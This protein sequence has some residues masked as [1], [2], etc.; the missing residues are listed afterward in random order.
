MVNPSVMQQ[1]A[2]EYGREDLAAAQAH[3]LALRL[4]YHPVRQRV[5]WSLVSLG[6]RLTKDPI[7]DVMGQGRHVRGTPRAGTA[8]PGTPRARTSLQLARL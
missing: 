6:M 5:G 1:L 7:L 2:R 4:S 8:P 3:G